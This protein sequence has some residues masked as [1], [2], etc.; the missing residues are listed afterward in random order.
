MARTFVAHAD[1]LV[2]R[3]LAPAL[4]VREKLSARAGTLH[5]V[6]SAK[7]L[8]ETHK[9]EKDINVPEVDAEELVQE[10]NRKHKKRR[11][12]RKSRDRDRR[13][14]KSS[15]SSDDSATESSGS[16]VPFRGASSAGSASTRAGRDAIENP[17]HVLIDTLYE[18]A[19]VLP[20]AAGE[21]MVTKAQLHK[22]APPLFST[23][24]G[25]GRSLASGHR[26][27]MWRR[28]RG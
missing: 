28:H 27:S 7:R 18:I 24:A 19:T 14:R 25:T 1:D 4:W 11:K 6:R 26:P 5:A 15:S 17:H 3:R 22:Q 21:A 8:V 9:A 12:R 16:D 2:A 20:R 10:L 23:R 13:R